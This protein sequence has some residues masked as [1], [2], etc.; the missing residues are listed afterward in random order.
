M[1]LN[2]NNF[3]KKLKSV[4]R[5]KKEK[6][7]SE[8]EVFS[9]TIDMLYACWDNSNKLYENFKVNTLEYEESFYRFIEN[10]ILLKYGLWKTEIILWYVFS[11]VDME[12]KIYPLL[13]QN[14]DDTEE[15]V[16]VN[17]ASELWEFIKKLEEKR[18]N[19]D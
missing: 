14:D 2:L 16:Y 13:V 6:I 1:K 5:S 4:K 9:E 8:E 3:G 15:E 19:E 10:L 12:G 17:N 7:L 18:K 11:R